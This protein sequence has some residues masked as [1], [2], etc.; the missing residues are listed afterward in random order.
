MKNKNQS[1]PRA[2][3]NCNTCQGTCYL[4]WCEPGRLRYVYTT[5]KRR[6]KYQSHSRSKHSCPNECTI[7]LHLLLRQIE[8]Y[9]R[10][11]LKVK[12][13]LHK[14]RF[15]VANKDHGYTGD[16]W[17]DPVSVASHWALLVACTSSPAVHAKHMYC[18]HLREQQ[19]LKHSCFESMIASTLTAFHTTITPTKERSSV[20]QC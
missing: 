10:Q 5:W 18:S 16:S 3:W 17:M 14:W 19:E 8:H 1:Y 2:Y 6:G 20:L 9:F 7:N 11:R 15:T 12:L 4:D 13:Q